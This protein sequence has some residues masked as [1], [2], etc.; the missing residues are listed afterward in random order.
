M[1]KIENWPS[2]WSFSGKE[3]SFFK[4][5]FLHFACFIVD[6]HAMPWKAMC[7]QDLEAGR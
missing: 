7:H 4:K 6:I 3:I 1:K 5:D 2:F